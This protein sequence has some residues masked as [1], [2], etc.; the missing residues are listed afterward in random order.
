MSTVFR[1]LC[2]NSNDSGWR[3]DVARQSSASSLFF[4][5]LSLFV[6]LFLFFFFLFFICLF[7]F[8]FFFCFCFF[9]CLF[10]CLFFVFFF[11]FF[12]FVLRFFCFFFFFFPRLFSL[13]LSTS[14]SLFG[15]FR[16]PYRPYPYL[17]KARTA[18]ARAALPISYKFVA[19]FTFSVSKQW[20][21][22]PCLGVL[23]MSVIANGGYTNTVRESAGVIHF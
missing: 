22:W 2:R 18:A 10:I 15:A 23:T 20:Y 4:F 5:F 13:F 14:L 7:F 11:V 12:F 21:G 3:K 17:D 16:S 19:C 6:C 1:H 8:R 9:V